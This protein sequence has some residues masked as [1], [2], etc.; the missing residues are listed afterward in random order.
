[1]QKEFDSENPRFWEKHVSKGYGKH[2]LPAALWDRIC[3]I[4]SR[5]VELRHTEILGSLSKPH[6]VLP[7][8]CRGYIIDHPDAFL[9]DEEE[10]KHIRNAP[11]D[12][13]PVT[14]RGHEGIVFFGLSQLKVVPP[15]F[16]MPLADMVAMEVKDDSE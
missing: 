12:L 9:L 5:P 6:T 4:R 3:K 7:E 14:I 16:D 13:V 8:G 2:N 11:P 15:F 1:M 10:K